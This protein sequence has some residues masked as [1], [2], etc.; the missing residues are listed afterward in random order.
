MRYHEHSLTIAK[1]Y[2]MLLFQHHQIYDLVI[3]PK[4]VSQA[5]KTEAKE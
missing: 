4:I 3:Q 5:I 2:T 1:V